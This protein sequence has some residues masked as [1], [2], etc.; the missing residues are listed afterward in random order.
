MR[1]NQRTAHKLIRLTRIDAQPH[2]QFD[3]FVKLGE[4]NLF[5]F[6]YGLFQIVLAA[7]VDLFRRSAIFL[8]V[9]LHLFTSEVQTRS[10]ISNLELPT[11]SP[12]Q[13][14]W[15]THPKINSHSAIRIPKS[16]YR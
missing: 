9:L 2:R 3:S 11:I 16:F 7:G 10:A 12:S 4:G 13:R 5:E 14:T 8:S 15:I 6:L 1:Q